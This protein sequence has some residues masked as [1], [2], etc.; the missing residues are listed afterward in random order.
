M[1]TAEDEGEEST[2]TK[3]RVIYKNKIK[4]TTV[5]TRK[6]RTIKCELLNNSSKAVLVHSIY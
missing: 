2:T 5:K 1:Q 6:N 3:S 4:T